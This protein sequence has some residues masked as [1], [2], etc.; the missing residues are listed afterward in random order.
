MLQEEDCGQNSLLTACGVQGFLTAGRKLPS[1]LAAHPFNHSFNHQ[2]PAG[3]TT[4]VWTTE[5]GGISKEHL[6]LQAGRAMRTP[7]G[8]GDWRAGDGRHPERSWMGE[9]GVTVG[10]HSKQEDQIG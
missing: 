5:T 8:Y 3:P 6:E 1:L 9:V 7:G 4:C 10:E 2:P